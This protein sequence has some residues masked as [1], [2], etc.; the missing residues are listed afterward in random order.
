MTSKPRWMMASVRF[1]DLSRT[2]WRCVFMLFCVCLRPLEKVTSLYLPSIGSCMTLL[3]TRQRC[4]KQHL[5]GIKDQETGFVLRT[6]LLYPSTD[7]SSQMETF[8]FAT[9][10][11]FMKYRVTFRLW[12]SCVITGPGCGCVV[13]LV[14]RWKEVVCSFLTNVFFACDG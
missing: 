13:F 8:P 11:H 9:R 6:T 3:R 14:Q 10:T 2:F 4:S 12:P 1:S 5:A 7:L